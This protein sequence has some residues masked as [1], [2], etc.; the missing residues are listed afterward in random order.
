MTINHWCEIMDQLTS[1]RAFVKVVDLGGFAAAARAFGLS[2]TMVSKHVAALEAR[3]GTALLTRTTR[4]VSATD[5]GR[6]F[7][8]RCQEILQ[9]VDEAEREAGE[10][11]REPVGCLRITAPVELGN[12]HIAPLLPPLM[13]RHP[14]LSV[15]LEF[16]N[17]VVDLVEEG[18]D[19][20]IRVAEVLDTSL[21]GRQLTSSRLVLV[22]SPS[23]LATRTPPNT[24][25]DLIAH[26]TLSFSLSMGPE[27][28]FGGQAGKRVIQVRPKLLSSSSEAV[29]TAALAGAGIALLPTFLVGAD[30][31]SGR[32]QQVMSSAS[33]GALKIF[34]LYP[35]RRTHPA[36]L[37]ALMTALTERFGHDPERDVFM[38]S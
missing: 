6:R 10:E 1:M 12:G 9:A 20:A 19:A 27:W 17:R 28:T 25:D 35:H 37:R 2:T 3:L 38:S 15:A 29:R 13:Q 31:V 30:L 21:R 11:G 33:L 8:G 5:A 34:V 16:S 14:G 22:A 23:Y 18:F 32:L 26:D 36:R 24:P 4:N 7:H